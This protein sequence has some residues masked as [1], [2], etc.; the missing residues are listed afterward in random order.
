MNYLILSD[1]TLLVC[2]AHINF[3][4]S[5]CYYKHDKPV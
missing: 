1:K 3:S 2:P 4:P 5:C